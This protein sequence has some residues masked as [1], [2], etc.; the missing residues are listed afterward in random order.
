MASHTVKQGEYLAKI[1][2]EYGFTDEQQ[3]WTYGPNAEIREAR[4][5]PNVLLPGDKLEI[6][7]KD[8]TPTSA[9]T[10][11][12]TRFRLKGSPPLLR[13]VLLDPDSEPLE[14]TPCK[15]TVSGEAFELVT[16]GNGQIEQVITYDAKEAELNVLDM[17]IP[18]LIGHLDPVGAKSGQQSRLEN[19]G[20]TSGFD[21]EAEE[22]AFLG[23]VEEFQCDH[24]LVVDGICGPNTQAKLA[25]IHG[26]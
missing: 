14:D 1:I 17:T 10:E 20:Y 11:K 5:S 8:T 25:E 24:G 13:L 6:P 22:K 15:L 16:D 21:T 18:M 9:P 26:S 4:E 12:R 2:R 3:I 23:A 7:D 19:L